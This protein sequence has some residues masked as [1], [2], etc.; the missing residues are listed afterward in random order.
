MIGLS[1][2][3]TSQRPALTSSMM[4]FLSFLGLGIQPP[5]G[6]L[7]S[8][9]AEGALQINPIRIYWWMIVF[10]GAALV[11]ALLALNFVGDGLRRLFNLQT[12]DRDG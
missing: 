3:E 6:S 2:P 7:G 8:L 1:G 12:S 11:T 10:P 9:I 5:Y 4:S